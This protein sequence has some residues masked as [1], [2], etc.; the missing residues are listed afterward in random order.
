MNRKTLTKI[1]TIS[2]SIIVMFTSSSAVL[3][4]C[5]FAPY[6]PL[7]GFGANGQTTTDIDNLSN[8]DGSDIAVQPDGKMIL[9][10]S[11]LTPGGWDFVI[12]R[13]NIDGSLDT[14]FGTS[15]IA[16]VDF[17]NR[18]DLAYGVALQS[19]GKIV[20]AGT[21]CIDGNFPSCNFALTRLNSNGS[22]DLMFGLLGRVT[23]DFDGEIDDAAKVAIQADGKIVVTGR[24]LMPGSVMRFAVA[25]YSTIGTL[26][27]TFGGDGTAA[28]GIG[29]Y[30]GANDLVVQPDGKI[31]VVGEGGY[32]FAALRLNTDGTLDS[33]F[34]PRGR[35]SVAFGGVGRARAVALQP[36]G[37]IVMGGLAQVLPGPG[38]YADSALIRLTANGMLDPSFDGDGKVVSSLVN[39]NDFIVDLVIMPGGEITS[40]AKL[41]VP[42]TT[43]L[44]VYYPSLANS[45]FYTRFSSLDNNKLLNA[46]AVQYSRIYTGGTF[47]SMG[48]QKNDLLAAVFDMDLPM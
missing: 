14:T 46:L 33:S 36:D 29:G 32:N 28:F 27:Q 16:T 12:A 41:D 10:G 13:Y 35:V 44:A 1:I 6:V 11:H 40:I 24:S 48:P 45:C 19:N 37:K 21:T 4:Q 18:V 47:Y 7:Y 3:A 17:S 20:V 43:G 42:Q 25:R 23:T 8:E 31:I 26:D 30:A 15:G 22:R 38:S 9:A 34:G 5:G 2:L 39:T